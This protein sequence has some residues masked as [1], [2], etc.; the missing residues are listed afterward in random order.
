MWLYLGSLAHSHANESTLRIFGLCLAT[1]AASEHFQCLHGSRGTHRRG[2]GLL[3]RVSS[4][5][6]E[7]L[8]SLN[9]LCCT[10]VSTH[11][12]NSACA[13][14]LTL[15]VYAMVRNIML[16]LTKGS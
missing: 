7:L 10:S 12:R 2:V 9:S 5:S 16:V 4:A 6:E 14:R 15:L 8:M 3:V 1:P 11:G 13:I